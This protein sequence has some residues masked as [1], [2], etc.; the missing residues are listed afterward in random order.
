MPSPTSVVFVCALD[1]SIS[2]PSSL[3]IAL[4]VIFDPDTVKD[5]VIYTEPVNSW[6]LEERLPNLVDPVI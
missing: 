2:P 6:V 1:N 4:T 3:P 5:P